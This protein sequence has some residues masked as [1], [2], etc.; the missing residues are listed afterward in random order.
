[1]LNHKKTI[2]PQPEWNE[3]LRLLSSNDDIESIYICGGIDTGKTSFCHYCVYSLSTKLPVAYVDCDP[4]QA[5]IGL[6]GTVGMVLRIANESHKEMLRFVGSNSPSGNLLQLVVGVVRLAQTAVERGA[7]KIFFDSCGLITGRFAEELHYH[8]VEVLGPHH[9]VVFQREQEAESVVR[10]FSYGIPGKIWKFRPSAWVENR[11]V[12][13]RRNYRN[14]RFREYFA[15]AVEQTI[16]LHKLVFH[17][18]VPDFTQRELLRGLFVALCDKD[19]FILA[20]GIIKELHNDDMVILSPLFDQRAVVSIQF[21]QLRLKQ[22]GEEETIYK[23]QI[24][25]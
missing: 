16:N 12:E 13:Q 22:S 4:G 6:P 19:G 2:R 9:V 23:N 10:Q 5:S 8:M 1:M 25:S 15:N 20:I 21:G 3:F 7:K 24:D 14:A 18:N 11:T 17:G